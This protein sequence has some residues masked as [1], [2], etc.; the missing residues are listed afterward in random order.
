MTFHK[1]R[2]VSAMAMSRQQPKIVLAIRGGQLNT[3]V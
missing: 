1:L 3:L 2:D